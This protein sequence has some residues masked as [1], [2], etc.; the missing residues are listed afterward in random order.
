LTLGP[1]PRPVLTFAT[2]VF[3]LPLFANIIVRRCCS[4]RVAYIYFVMAWR[5][6]GRN[7]LHH[8]RAPCSSAR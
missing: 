7:F 2:C 6:G 4:A 3:W 1:L 8:F 5:A